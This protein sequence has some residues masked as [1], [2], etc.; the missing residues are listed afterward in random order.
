MP[1]M[2]K[3]VSVTTTPEIQQRRS[4]APTMVAMGTAAFFSAWTNSGLRSPT[5]ALARA[6][7]I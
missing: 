2:L 5:P 1:G 6:V 7:R 3:I 4:P